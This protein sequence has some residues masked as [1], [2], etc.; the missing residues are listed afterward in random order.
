MNF[1]LVTESTPTRIQR[2]VQR[3]SEGGEGVVKK[4]KAEPGDRRFSP[5]KARDGQGLVGHPGS[6]SALSCVVKDTSSTGARIELVAKR[7]DEQADPYAVPDKMT[8]V[9]VT[10][11][12]QTEVACQ[13][14]WR[15]GKELGLRYVGPFRTFAKAQRK[16]P[17]R[18]K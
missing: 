11:A 4:T 6:Q 15:S 3:K 9:F 8:L 17:D 5:R 7:P 2:F 18:R 12:D 16:M 1:V 14:M 13:V 10:S